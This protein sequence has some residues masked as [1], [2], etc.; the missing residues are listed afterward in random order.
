MAEM[1]ATA[2]ASRPLHLA[3]HHAN[4]PEDARRVLAVIERSASIVEAYVTEFTQVMAVHT[5]PGLV[6]LAWWIDETTVA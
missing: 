5:G 3:V 1:L 4:A 6:A 2:A